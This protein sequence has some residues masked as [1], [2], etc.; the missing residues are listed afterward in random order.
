[1]LY[2]LMWNLIGS[3]IIL[4]IFKHIA[5][6][7]ERKREELEERKERE[8]QELLLGLSIKESQVV[9]DLV[10]HSSH[11]RLVYENLWQGIYM[12]EI[13]DDTPS[14]KFYAIYDAKY[15][16]YCRYIWNFYTGS[17]G[18]DYDIIKIVGYHRS[19]RKEGL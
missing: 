13:Y 14:E 16:N 3:I 4:I 7:K 2:F 18:D 9:R 19:L 15:N 10:I 5:D 17:G 12:Y 6:K 1:M 11:Y 8:L